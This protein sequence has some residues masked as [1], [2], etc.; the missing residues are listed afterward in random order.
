MFRPWRLSRIEIETGTSSPRGLVSGATIINPSLAAMRCAPAF[1]VKL[2]SV[3][4]RPDSQ[5][6]V[7]YGPFPWI[8]A[9][10]VKTAKR[11]SQESALLACFHT[12]CSPPKDFEEEIR[13]KACSTMLIVIVVGRHLF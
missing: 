6:S 7:G 13:S 5:K 12:A 1:T 3:Q 8:S 10:G 9:G 11:M 4:V 2:S